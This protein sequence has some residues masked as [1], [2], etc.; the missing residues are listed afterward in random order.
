[1][2]LNLKCR[3]GWRLELE[4]LEDRCLP[5]AS[6]ASYPIVPVITEPT[7]EHLRAVLAQGL[8]MGNQLDVFAKVGDSITANND[9][10]VPLGS[11]FYDPSNPA[12][13]GSYT[14]LAPTIDYFRALP[15]PDGSNS[16]NRVSLA[17]HGGWTT[18]DVLGSLGAGPLDVELA[19]TRP[20]FALIMIG[21]NDIG[22]DLIHNIPSD[23]FAVNITLIVRDTL[24]HG[25]IPVLSTIPDIL[26]PGLEPSVFAY[27]Q[28]IAD[29]AAQYDVPLWNYW[30][31]MQG[32]PNWGISGDGVHPSP[33]PY[34]SGFLTPV[35]L[36]FGY[37]MRNLTGV[38]VLDKLTRV[39]TFNGHPDIDFTTPLTPG[40]IQYVTNLYDTVLGR[41]PEAAGLNYWG[42]LVQGGYSRQEV[43]TD[44]WDSVEHRALEVNQY[45][46]TYLHRSPL[47]GEQ[48]AWVAAFLNGMSE[49][50]A[51]VGFLVSAEYQAAH[52]GNSDYLRALYND[53]LGRAPDPNGLAAGEQALRAGQSRAAIA[54]GFL[55]AVETQQRA[56]DRFYLTLL[57]RPA[58]PQGEQAGVNLLIRT[59]AS[60]EVAAEGILASD[61]FASVAR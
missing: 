11:P 13:A 50:Q 37:D 47:P 36:L 7:K 3:R 27:N 57:G 28:I 32:L 55:G 46:A 41:K 42:H 59:G 6:F 56:V 17:A 18:Y 22:F 14:N 19:V 4:P 9:F 60:P 23:V 51:Q 15:L 29:V 5:A 38:E 35:G 8:Q 45:Y 21:T 33:C 40:T 24:A 10:M 16:F 2:T 31:A 58:D 39:L 52:P 54:L 1:M 43:A 12:V 30:L 49:V 53:I 26:L 48:A 25:V 20:A 44:I 61:E 34:G